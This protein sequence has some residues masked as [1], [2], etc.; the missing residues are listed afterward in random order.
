MQ[1]KAQNADAR[2]W[3][4]K[5]EFAH[6][7]NSGK[8]EKANNKSSSSDNNNNMSSSNN[9]SN[10][11]SGKKNNKKSDKGQKQQNSGKQ[12]Q[13]SR[14]TLKNDLS[15][16]LDLSGKLTQ[17]EHQCRMDNNL[18]LFC[19]KGGHKVSDCKLKDNSSKACAVTTSSTDSESKEKKPAEP[20]KE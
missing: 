17:Q 5:A 8:P 13:A 3:E 9:N 11:N 4:R 20:K 16:K 12:Q 18:C 2:Y 7:N 6:E 19:G 1:Q 10:N 15:S 14:S